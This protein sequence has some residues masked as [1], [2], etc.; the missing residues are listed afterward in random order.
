MCRVRSTVSR[1]A[2]T[3]STST[4][5][6]PLNARSPTCFQNVQAENRAPQPQRSS[7]R[8]SRCQRWTT[9][10]SAH[11]PGSSPSRR[12]TSVV[13]LRP[14]P[15]RNSTRATLVH[16]RSFRSYNERTSVKEATVSIEAFDRVELDGTG[17]D[18]ITEAE[19]VAVV[20][21]ALTT[22]R[23]GRIITPNI[24]IL[25]RAQ[26]EA[27]ARQHLADAD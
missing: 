20:R 13:P 1:S 5:A 21:E 7:S 25:R 22:G 18:R 17:I 26:V 16:L 9:S 6:Q 11:T 15:P 3:R 23:G 2:C 24:D 4:L 27:E 10:P 19:V 12:S 8:M 14:N